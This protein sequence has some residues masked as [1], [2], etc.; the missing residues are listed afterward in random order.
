[1]L[2]YWLWY[3]M[4]KKLLVLAVDGAEAK[5]DREIRPAR[6]EDS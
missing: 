5:P 1:M 3:F 2:D 6:D 4:E